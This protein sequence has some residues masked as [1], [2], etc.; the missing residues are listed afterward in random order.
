MVPEE[1]H[2]NIANWVYRGGRLI[3]FGIYLMERHHYGNHNKLMRRF[4]I[5]FQHNLIMPDYK[6][7][8]YYCI[9]QAFAYQDQ[10]LWM[11]TK[12]QISP[13]DHPIL[14][15]VGPVAIT[16]SCTITTAA[17]PL[18]IISTSEKVPIMNAFGPQNPEGRLLRAN[19]YELY[20]RDNA[21]FMA[22]V[23]YGDGI[24]IGIGSWKIFLNDLIRAYP[25]GNL[26][27]LQNSIVWLIN[28]SGKYQNSTAG[29]TTLE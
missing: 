21:P 1:E 14:K 8:T 17:K 20:K 25:S 29:E 15:D 22:A 3:T 18:F 27:L 28:N 4:G 5:E 23:R 9:E 24:V 13:I 19:K 7:S 12:P 10:D 11:I 26:K 16:S 6:E 2:A